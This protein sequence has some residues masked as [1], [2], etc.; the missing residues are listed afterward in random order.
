MS[1]VAAWRA[2]AWALAWF[3]RAW[4][5]SLRVTVVCDPRAL[6]GPRVLA[7]L[8]AQQLALL[9]VGRPRQTHAL[10]SWSADG[11]LQAELLAAF[12]LGVARGSSTRGG[13]AGLRALVRR[14]RAGEDAAFAVD[15]PRGPAGRVKPGALAAARLGRA[16]LIPVAVAAS[17][18][19]GVRARWESFE[20]PWP[21]SRVAIVLGGPVPATGGPERLERALTSARAKAASLVGGGAP[22]AS[23]C[24]VSS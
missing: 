9:A 8:H 20:V 23:A 12:G 6:A 5:A 3:L 16:A 2:G 24:E 21:F 17:R 18:R 19:F 22:G 10:V 1:R 13:A 4:V 11:A 7:F 15:G 14:L